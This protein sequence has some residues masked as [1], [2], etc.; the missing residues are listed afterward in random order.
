M[1]THQLCQQ[2]PSSPTSIEPD[3]K[4]LSTK[5][6]RDD[7]V[8]YW[9]HYNLLL[10][11]ISTI[12]IYI[13]YLFFNRTIFFFFFKV[14][15]YI[16][17]LK[18]MA[19][20]LKKVTKNYSSLVQKYMTFQTKMQTGAFFIQLSNHPSTKSFIMIRNFFPVQNVVDRSCIMPIRKLI[21]N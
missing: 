14:M 7:S 15:K 5:N 16:L 13:F 9:Y 10:I 20:S 1:D 21:T 4:K 19:G 17:L 6:N 18:E 2:T 8:G 12:R 3:V 11:L